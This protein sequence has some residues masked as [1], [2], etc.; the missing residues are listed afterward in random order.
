MGQ[1]NYR[2]W[3][4]RPPQEK[5]D[6]CTSRI[7]ISNTFRSNAKQHVWVCLSNVAPFPLPTS[8][9][10]SSSFFF[11]PRSFVRSIEWEKRCR[12]MITG[13]I[14]PRL[15]L[16]RTCLG[17]NCGMRWGEG[18]RNGRAASETPSAHWKIGY[19]KKLEENRNRYLRI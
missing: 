17:L 5:G 11:N 16:L 3:H 8:F 12:R 6:Q 10:S 18:K 9:S 13:L 2:S 19:R 7:R 14:G 1:R 4:I 15:L